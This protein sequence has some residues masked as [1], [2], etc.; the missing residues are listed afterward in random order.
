MADETTTLTVGGRLLPVEVF[1]PEGRDPARP[2]PAVLVLSQIF[3]LDDDIRRICR[4]FAANGYL[5]AAPDYLATGRKLGCIARALRALGSGEGGPVPELEAAIAMLERRE[6]VGKVGVAGFCM[7]GGFALLL[8]CRQKVSAAAVYY[9]ETR[10][11]AELATACPLVGGYGGRDRVFRGKA[12]RLLRD[13]DE[14]GKEH[15]VRI[16]EDAG[17]AYMNQ[18]PPPVAK[19]LSRPLMAVDYHPEAAE[20][21]WARMLP[22]FERHLA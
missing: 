7:G 1:L 22:F 9:G 12:Q 18:D 10:S 15:D 20:D 3:G 4:R 21:S 16:Y 5:A 2:G 17:H 19:L 8:G 14:L 6:D 11:R 13:L